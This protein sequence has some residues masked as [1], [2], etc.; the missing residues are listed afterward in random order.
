MG[1]QPPYSHRIRG[2]H[3]L[4]SNALM[5]HNMTFHNFSLT[6]T[7]ACSYPSLHLSTVAGIVQCLQKVTWPFIGQ[8]R[9]NTEWHVGLWLSHLCFMAG[10]VL[11]IYLST[12]EACCVNT[13]ICNSSGLLSRLVQAVIIQ[14]TWHNNLHNR[15]KCQS[16]EVFGRAECVFAMWDWKCDITAFC[17]KIKLFW[18][19]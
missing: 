16:W 4:L 9:V 6:S 17:L 19:M 12:R 7:F 3:L 5:L 10:L 14:S 15:H 2:S 8:W 18:I 11:F 13:W 1:L